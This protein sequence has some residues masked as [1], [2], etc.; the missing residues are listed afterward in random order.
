ME[1]EKEV[2]EGSPLLEIGYSI[3][4]RVFPYH[5]QHPEIYHPKL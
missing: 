5:A 1:T 3:V 2:E 4:G